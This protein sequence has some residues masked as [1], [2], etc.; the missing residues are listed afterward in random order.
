MNP[1]KPPV[2]VGR[3]VEKFENEPEADAKQSAATMR[4]STALRMVKT[5]WKSPAFLMPR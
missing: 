1:L 5:S 2:A 3:D 4:M